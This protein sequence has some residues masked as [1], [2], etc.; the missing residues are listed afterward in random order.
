MSPER[1]QRFKQTVVEV[2]EPGRAE[3]P[4]YLVKKCGG[5]IDL[6]LDVS[7][8]LAASRSISDFI[9]TPA[10][11]VSRSPKAAHGRVRKAL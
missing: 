1:W 3:W 4:S 8:L 6:F 11:R 2:M 10:W 7:S 5:D 9:K